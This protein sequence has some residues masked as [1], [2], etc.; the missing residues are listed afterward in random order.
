MARTNRSQQ[1]YSAGER[2]R[3][4]VRVFPDSKTGIYQM[5]WRENGRR[6]GRSLKHRDR[7]RAKRQA[8]EF[9]AD[10]AAP[11][12]GREPEPLTLGK[13]FEMYLGIL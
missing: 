5:E 3:N 7:E 8:D 1:N 12:S 10:Y 11:Q 6:L 4:R 13:L 9:A 2:G